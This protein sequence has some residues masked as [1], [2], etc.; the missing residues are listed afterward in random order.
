MVMALNDTIELM[1]DAPQAELI[2]WYLQDSA[3]MFSV[4][5]ARGAGKSAC[6]RALLLVA[7]ISSRKQILY[8]S[9]SSGN[10]LDQFQKLISDPVVGEYLYRG[11]D[12]EPYSLKPVPVIRFWN[13]TQILFWSMAEGAKN[14]KRG[15]HPSLLIIDEA[16]SISRVAYSKILMPMRSRMGRPAKVVVAGSCPDTD[17]QWSWELH[18]R[19][20]KYPNP[21][22]VK[23]FTFDTN[24]SLAFKGPHGQQMLAEAKANMS[25]SDFESEYLLRPGG[26]GDRYFKGP[27]IDECVRLF[28]ES[29]VD[30]EHGTILVLD[31]S[32]GTQDPMAYLIGDLKGNVIVAHS[33]PSDIP[34]TDQINEVI[35]MATRYKSLVVV[36]SNGTAATTYMGLLRQ[37]LPYELMDI[38]M[39]GI[40]TKAGEAKNVLCKNTAWSLENKAIHISP[41]CERLIVELKSIR[42]YKTPSGQVQIKAPGREH[43]DQFACFVLYVEALKLGWKPSLNRNAGNPMLNFI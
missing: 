3:Q 5:G 14:T 2:D 27:A 19:G 11:R 36:E 20:Q 31:P 42:D 34:D 4:I 10:S 1:L 12:C 13:G 24:R 39:R 38:P 9:Q 33:I 16:Q 32:L 15:L 43:D 23:S 22:G 41:E 7:A 21:S 40:S 26:Q 30:L 18:Q 37:R 29:E 28:S 35:E 6:L 17:G 25:E 8:S